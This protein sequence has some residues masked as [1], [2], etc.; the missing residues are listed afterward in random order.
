M[1]TNVDN[2]SRLRLEYTL[3]GMRTLGRKLSYH[4]DG[5]NQGF[6]YTMFHLFWNDRK[7]LVIFMNYILSYAK[8]LFIVWF[9]KIRRISFYLKLWKFR[10]NFEYG[11]FVL[12]RINVL[13]VRAWQKTYGNCWTR[14]PWKL[15]WCLQSL[16]H[17]Y[18]QKKNQACVLRII[19]S[20]MYLI[21]SDS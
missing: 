2:V 7:A 12:R 9:R 19:S 10:F 6:L 13:K 1:R 21:L 16:V 5:H 11:C 18:Q 14:F 20:W 15:W 3:V 4:N 17:T 8:L